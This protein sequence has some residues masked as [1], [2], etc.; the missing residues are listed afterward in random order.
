MPEAI[1]VDE[2]S[3]RRVGLTV[4]ATELVLVT[5]SVFGVVVPGSPVEASELGEYS[6]PWPVAAGVPLASW[7]DSAVCSARAASTRPAPWNS[8]GASRS[9]ELDMR[10]CFTK[11]GA[12]VAPPWVLRYASMTSAAVAAVSG[13][14]SLVPPKATIGC[15]WGPL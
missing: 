8:P 3:L 14:D 11:S 7:M 1:V 10:I 15:G 5:V 13:H 12:G 4:C 6:R 2:P 9:W